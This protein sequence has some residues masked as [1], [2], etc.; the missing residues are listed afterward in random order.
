MIIQQMLAK[1]RIDSKDSAKNAIREICQEIALAGLCEGNF[2]KKASFYG[3]TALRILYDLPRFSEDLDFSL[4]EKN[5]NFNIE[6][7]FES[8]ISEFEA[9]NIHIDIKKKHKAD[10]SIESALLSIKTSELLKNIDET[11]KIKI[12]VDKNP[13]LHF[14]NQSKILLMPKS[15]SLN[16]MTLPNLFAGK[17]HAILFREWKLRVKGRDYFDLEWYVKNN[18]LLNLEHLLCRMNH[19]GNSSND[20]ITRKDLESLLLAKIDKIDI[21]KAIDDVKSFVLNPKELEIWSK[22]Y[23]RFL[24]S[25]MQYEQEQVEFTSQKSLSENITQNSE[26]K[27]TIHKRKH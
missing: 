8:I 27:S 13:P 24:I 1:Y 11:I 4:L 9:L 22:D 5:E 17:I 2:F 18:V 23:F 10:S 6:Q 7:Y 19:F 20:S 15:F 25:K 26:S 21:Q 3:G 12:D 14:Q 16:A